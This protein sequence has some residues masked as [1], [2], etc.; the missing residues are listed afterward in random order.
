MAEV[1]EEF[2]KLVETGIEFI[3]RMGLKVVEMRRGYVELKAPLDGNRSHVGTMYAGALFSLAE[4]PG[5]ALY[6]SSFDVS[7]YYPIVK[8][9]TIR[10]KKPVVTDATVKVEMSEEEMRRVAGE[11]DEK[12]KS[13]FLLKAEVFDEAGRLVCESTATYQLRRMGT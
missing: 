10:Y 13:E 1:S 9:M 4:V 2:V 11:A 5:G 3:R 8:E 6:L 7:R 12:G